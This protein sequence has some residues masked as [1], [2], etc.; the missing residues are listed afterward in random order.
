MISNIN[1]I[2]I[3]VRSIQEARKFYEQTLG[4]KIKEVMDIPARGVRVAFVEDLH[5]CIEL[6]EPLDEDSPVFRFLEKRGEGIHH[7]AFDVEN[8]ERALQ[9]ITEKGVGLITPSPVTGTHGKKIGFLSPADTHG[10]LIE[11]TEMSQ[12]V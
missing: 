6:V 3:A 2:G 12:T 11:L 10:V 7:I 9:E 8:I 4:L 1:H 5:P